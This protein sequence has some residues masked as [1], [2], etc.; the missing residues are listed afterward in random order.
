MA[1][2]SHMTS[3][4]QS[5]LTTGLGISWLYLQSSLYTFFLS[6]VL[7]HL[8]SITFSISSMSSFS[9]VLTRTPSLFH[10]HSLSQNSFS[11]SLVHSHSPRVLH[12]LVTTLI[13]IFTSIFPHDCEHTWEEKFFCSK[14]EFIFGDDQHSC[15]FIFTFAKFHAKELFGL[16]LFSI[17]S[18][19]G[20]QP[21]CQRRPKL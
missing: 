3:F 1:L 2:S 9:Q 19:L 17:R 11:P 15:F 21:S 12:F 20:T 6:L 7:S 5:I 10:S 4:N 16:P 13:L 8:L 14:G 18:H